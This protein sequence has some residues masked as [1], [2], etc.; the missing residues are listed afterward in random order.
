MEN[1]GAPYHMTGAHRRV[2]QSVTGVHPPRWT[3][4]VQVTQGL[5]YYA[6]ADQGSCASVTVS[7]E[8]SL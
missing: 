5:T 4:I 3:Q 6:I 7:P 1:R 8:F 2:Y